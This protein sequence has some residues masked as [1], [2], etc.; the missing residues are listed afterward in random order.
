[1][2]IVADAV[3]IVG[4]GNNMEDAMKSHEERLHKFLQ[5]CVAQHIVLN[6]S[7]FELRVPS[8]VFMGHV[9]GPDGIRPDRT[10]VRAILEMPTSSDVAGVRRFLGVINFLSKYVPHLSTLVRPIQLLLSEDT[11]WNWSHEH[12][13]AMRRVKVLLSAAPY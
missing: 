5:W 4:V 7:K 8:M 13:G 6:E 3:V 11:V 9:F 10:T 2:H 1:M 12:E